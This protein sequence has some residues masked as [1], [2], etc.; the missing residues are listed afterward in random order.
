MDKSLAESDVEGI[1]LTG[2]EASEV[3]T[4]KKVLITGASFE[5]K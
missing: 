5:K 2:D 4:G 1:Y 3:G